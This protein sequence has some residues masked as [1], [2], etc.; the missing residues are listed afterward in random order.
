VLAYLFGYG[1]L[2]VRSFPIRL[3]SHRSDCLNNGPIAGAPEP[4]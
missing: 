4:L 1:G 3:T 2:L